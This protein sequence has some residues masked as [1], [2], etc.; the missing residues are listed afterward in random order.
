MT[1]EIFKE[2]IIRNMKERIGEDYMLRVSEVIK[3]NGIKLTGITATNKER[4]IG[5]TFYAEHLYKEYFSEDE[6]AVLADRLYELM[7]RYNPEEDLDLSDLFL[8]AT[9]RENIYAK[10]INAKLNKDLL[11]QVPHHRIYDLAIVFYYLLEN[12]KLGGMGTILV[13]ND[14]MKEWGVSIED[15]FS[16]AM[17]NTMDHFPVK[18]TNLQEV[19]KH[20]LEEECKEGEEDIRFDDPV[21]NMY[22][23]TNE[24]SQFGAICA[25]YKNALKDIA[26]KLQRNLYILPSSVHELI[27]VPDGFDI[28]AKSLL[29]MVKEVNDTTLEA[30]EILSYSVYF[31]DR[32]TDDLRVFEG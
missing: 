11:S 1:F 6:V 25:F 12:E 24:P 31:Y 13:R 26:Y 15:V 27:L 21:P 9:A 2:L 32:I 20:M 30:D 7:V 29:K 22:V 4:N 8:Y 28:D 10:V 16:D 17:K 5:P 19:I 3:N 23:L 18:C 14:I